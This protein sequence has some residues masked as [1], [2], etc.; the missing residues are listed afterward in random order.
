DINNVRH[1][2][3]LA[4]LRPITFGSSVTGPQDTAFHLVDIRTST[5][6]A[7]R[8]HPRD[9]VHWVHVTK[10]FPV[11]AGSAART[12]V[13]GGD[14]DPIDPTTEHREW[15]YAFQ[16]LGRTWALR[17]RPTSDDDPLRSDRI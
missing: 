2:R 8:Y 16:P 15:R 6:I 12:Q 1:D 5:V 17:Q 9:L 10:T 11:A 3:V 13:V 4:D 7:G 14:A